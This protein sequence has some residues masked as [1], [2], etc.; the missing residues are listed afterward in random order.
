MSFLWSVA[1]LILNT[2]FDIRIVHWICI[3]FSSY[4]GSFIG[5]YWTITVWWPLMT[6]LL[7]I[8][9]YTC[10]YISTLCTLQVFTRSKGS[11][12]CLFVRY[13]KTKHMFMHF[14]HLGKYQA[15]W[16]N[17]SGYKF[18]WRCNSRPSADWRWRRIEGA[19]GVAG[20]QIWRGSFH[21]GGWD[22]RFWQCTA[23]FFLV[24]GF[25]AFG[26][27]N[28][29]HSYNISKYRYRLC[30]YLTCCLFRR[31]TTAAG[32]TAQDAGALFLEPCNR[33]MDRW[34][35]KTWRVVRSRF[36]DPKILKDR[37]MFL[38]YSKKQLS[39]AAFKRG[40]SL[41]LHLSGSK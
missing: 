33:Y 25:F 6:Y 8:H 21:L 26:C 9:V 36:T 1:S 17:S 22:A 38:R 41:F 15:L 30:K 35:L 7:Y 11:S 32:G 16:S 10:I 12:K 14:L 18:V 29:G 5:Y 20:F 23:S 13:P 40:A 24:H 27:L 19:R 31:R 3:V 2:V 4:Y 28:A 37:W 34:C 39:T